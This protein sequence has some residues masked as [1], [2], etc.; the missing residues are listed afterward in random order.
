MTKPK[1]IK[2]PPKP[3]T[4][5]YDGRKITCE[6]IQ[7]ILEFGK[8]PYST[9]DYYF[10]IQLIEYPEKEQYLRFTHYWKEEN[11]DRWHHHISQSFSAPTDIVQRLLVKAQE[12]GML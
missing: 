3:R 12:K 11:E 8:I 5:P 9:K 7:E 1:G 2:R 10:A 6:I 4:L